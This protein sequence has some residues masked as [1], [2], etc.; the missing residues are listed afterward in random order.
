MS[1]FSLSLSLFLSAFE[2]NI[3]AFMII[4]HFEFLFIEHTFGNGAIDTELLS[5]KE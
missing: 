4:N 5:L 1:L 2:T 3:Y